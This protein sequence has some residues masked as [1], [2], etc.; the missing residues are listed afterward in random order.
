MINFFYKIVKYQII[1][2]NSVNRPTYPNKNILKKYP[3]FI[4]L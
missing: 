1:P 2:L 4:I 3:I